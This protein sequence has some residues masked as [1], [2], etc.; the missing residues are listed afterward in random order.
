MA[1]EDTTFFND[2]NGP[3]YRYNPFIQYVIRPTLKLADAHN[4]PIRGGIAAALS[5][6]VAHYGLVEL[7]TQASDH[8]FGTNLRDPQTKLALTALPWY[9]HLCFG[10]NM[11]SNI[12]TGIGIQKY[13]KKN[14]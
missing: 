5:S 4:N 7:V 13:Y 14:E 11:L 2:K 3:Y 8:F 9:I 1:T 12:V 6:G 10:V